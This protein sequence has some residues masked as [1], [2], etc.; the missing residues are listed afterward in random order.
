[1]ISDTTVQFNLQSAMALHQSGRLMKAASLYKQVLDVD[2]KNVDALHLLGLVFHQSGQSATAIKLIKQA[3]EVSPN[4]S[5]Y[6]RN[7]ADILRESGQ[8]KESVQIYR[9][10]IDSIQDLLKYIT[11]WVLVYLS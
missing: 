4:Q 5:D 1:M 10:I 11:I 2:P 6:L 3:L 8:F 7:L 9:R